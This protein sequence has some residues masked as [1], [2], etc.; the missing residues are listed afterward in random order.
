MTDL[1]SK[2]PEG[3]DSMIMMPLMTPLGELPCSSQARAAVHVVSFTPRTRAL[4]DQFNPEAEHAL[5]PR[6][7]HQ[8]DF[9]S[10][11]PYTSRG[12]GLSVRC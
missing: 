3:S 1:P 2:G 8:P 10:V 9:N 7:P 4:S 5:V 12:S 6:P 11:V